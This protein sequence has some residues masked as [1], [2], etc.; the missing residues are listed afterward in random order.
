MKG[1]VKK[2]DYMGRINKLFV[3]KSALMA[4]ANA[5]M[6]AQ[7]LL[8]QMHLLTCSF[9]HTYIYTHNHT[10]AKA[11]VAKKAGGGSM[12]SASSEGRSRKQKGGGGG[13]G[14]STEAEDRS[15]Q[16]FPSHSSELKEMAQRQ[17]K[18]KQWEDEKVLERE[19]IIEEVR[20]RLGFAALAP[21]PA[22]TSVVVAAQT[23]QQPHTQ[24]KK[25]KW[26]AAVQAL[27]NPK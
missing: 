23:Q 7:F 6:N 24:T 19:K 10:I 3:A 2:Y 8:S 22:M 11:N 20:Q 25:S 4:K 27:H 9:T 17:S 26:Q 12:A 15:L 1:P 18:Y 14:V 13:A 16:S 5:G 21:A